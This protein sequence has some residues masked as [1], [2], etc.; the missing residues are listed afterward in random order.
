MSHPDKVVF[1]KQAQAK[2]YRTYLYFVAT[3]DPSIIVSRVKLRVSQGGHDVPENKIRSRYVRSL[4]LLWDAI[5]LSNRAYIFDNSKDGSDRTWLA[6][7]TNGN[8]FDIKSDMFPAWF[9]RAVWD[10]IQHS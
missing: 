10:K 4:N 1:L 7:V 6:E 2:G 8:E 3:D 5:R 9:Q